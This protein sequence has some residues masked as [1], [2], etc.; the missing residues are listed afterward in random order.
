MVELEHPPLEIN[1]LQGHIDL[2]QIS[3][4]DADVPLD[5]R[6]HNS[7][8]SFPPFIV[9][10][11]LDWSQ[12]D[13]LNQMLDW[14]LDLATTNNMKTKDDALEYLMKGDTFSIG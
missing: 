2:S 3:R 14:D 13:E 6:N 1:N 11:E 9:S 7:L 5:E 4:S 8:T 12:Q 10:N